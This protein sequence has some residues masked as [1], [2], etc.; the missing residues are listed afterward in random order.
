MKCRGPGWI[1]FSLST[2]TGTSS[3]FFRTPGRPDSGFR[4]GAGPGPR[5]AGG[6]GSGERAEDGAAV[7]DADG[8]AARACADVFDSAAGGPSGQRSPPCRRAYEGLAACVTAY[9]FKKIS[10]RERGAVRE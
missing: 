9:V 4:A 7:D 3:G 6:V 1:P 5:G 8:E 2:A 10:G